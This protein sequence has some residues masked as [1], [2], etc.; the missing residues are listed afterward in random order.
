MKHLHDN[1]MVK[2]VCW[3]CG[4]D[5]IFR[6]A[7]SYWDVNKQDWVLNN[8]Y[9]DVSCRSCGWAGNLT[10]ETTLISE[11]EVEE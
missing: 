11:E 3:S 10:E 4:S 6:E 9:D 5:N 7:D 1:I 8:V 2:K